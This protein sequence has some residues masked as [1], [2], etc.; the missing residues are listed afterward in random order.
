MSKRKFYNS[1]ERFLVIAEARTNAVLEKIRILGNCSNTQLYKYTPEEI[2]KIFRIIDLELNKA[3]T[4]FHFIKK[5][6]FR[7]Q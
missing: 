6:E 2:S 5:T 1:R 3:K 7:L 4:K